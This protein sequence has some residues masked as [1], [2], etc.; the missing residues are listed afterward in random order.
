MN[1]HDAIDERLRDLAIEYVLRGSAGKRDDEYARHLDVCDLCRDEVDELRSDVGVLAFL[2]PEVSPRRNLLSRLTGA[3]P[4]KSWPD[5]RPAAS[6]FVAASDV[7][8]KT[9][10]P[11]VLA[12]RLFV[13]R[14]NDRV[15]MLVRMNAGS[16]Y[17]GHSH[18]GAEECFVVSG[19]LVVGELHMRGGDFQRSELGSDHPVQRTEQGCLLLITSSLHDQLHEG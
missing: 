9:A 3:Q 17:P 12:R 4:W 11:G 8:E 16:E 1:P 5:Q 2:A 6:T 13:D 15:T 19:D 18:G 14:E 10:Y 7:W